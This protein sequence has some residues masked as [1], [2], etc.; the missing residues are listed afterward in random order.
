MNFSG[1]IITKY[2][3]SGKLQNYPDDMDNYESVILLKIKTSACDH[4]HKVLRISKDHQICIHT[5]TF[6]DHQI[7][8]SEFKLEVG[9]S[10][11]GEDVSDELSRK[12]QITT[13]LELSMS[14]EA[15]P[16]KSEVG[17]K[18]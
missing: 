12:F 17:A 13:I 4:L 18:F 6:K 15:S 7:Q 2:F 14:V 10:L 9:S 3:E 5:R 1:K 11:I 8:Q 16:I